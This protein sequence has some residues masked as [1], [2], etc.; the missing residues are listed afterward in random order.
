MGKSIISSMSAGSEDIVKTKAKQQQVYL[1]ELQEVDNKLYQGRNSRSIDSFKNNILENGLLQPIIVIETDTGYEILAGHKR[2]YAHQLLVA[3]G[4]EQFDEIKAWVFEKDSLDE[5][6]K[7]KV[8]MGTNSHSDYTTEEKKAILNKADALYDELKEAGKKPIGRKHE[9]IMA[10]TG[11][12]ESVARR[13]S[14][15]LR[16]VDNHKKELDPVLTALQ[17]KLKILLATNVKVKPKSFT[18]HYKDYEDLNRILEL[19]DVLEIGENL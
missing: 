2:V 10:L 16:V 19:L 6:E 3:D 4:H 5:L 1:D 7:W 12:G 8:K 13:R 18:V 14:N 11:F 9:W 15:A 17:Q